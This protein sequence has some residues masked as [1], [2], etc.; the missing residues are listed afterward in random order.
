[1]AQPVTI[2]YDHPDRGEEDRLV[3]PSHIFLGQSPHHTETKHACWYLQGWCHDKRSNRHF[4]LTRVTNW[5][6][7]DARTPEPTGGD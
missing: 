4:P 1:M 2:T 7:G 5:R 3:T 6:E